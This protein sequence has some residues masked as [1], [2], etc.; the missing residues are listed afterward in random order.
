VV[1]ASSITLSDSILEVEIDPQTGAL[2][3]V[4]HRQAGLQLIAQPE[5]AARNPFAVVLMDGTLVKE[6]RRCSIQPDRS[7]SRATITWILDDG[8]ELTVDLELHDGSGELRCMPSLRNDQGIP[9]AAVAYPYIAGIGHLSESVWDDNLVHP[10]ATGFLVRNPLESLPAVESET[11]GQQP[12]VLGLYPE[13]FSGSTMQFMAYGSANRGGFY[14]ATE[15]SEGREKWLNFYR[16]GAGDL[17]LS[18][19]HAPDNYAG[20]YAVAPRYSTV[21]AALDGGTWYDAAERYKT[22]AVTQPWVAQGKTSERADRTT[23]LLQDVGLCT[24]GIS[25]RHDRAAWLEEIHRIAG[26]P[27]LHVLGPHW[28]KTEAN[29]MG[30]LPGGLADWFPAQF[31]PANMEMIRRNGDYFVPFEF[32]LFFGRGED[33]AEREAGDAAL[34][35]IP[36]P[37]FSRDAYDFPFLCPVEPFT[38]ELHAARDRTLVERYGVDGVYYDISVNN[39]RHICTSADH[40]HRPGDAAALTAAYRALMATTSTAM[41][42]ASGGTVIPQ[43]TEMINE[44]MIPYISFYQARAEASPASPFEAWPFRELIKTGAAEKIPLFTY[45]YHEYGPLRLD[46]W[47]KLSREQGELVYFILGRIFLQGGLIELN[48]EFS[49]LETHGENYDVPHEHYY[50]F[51]DRRYPIDGDVATF[52][53]TL[54]RMR[55]GAANRYLAYGSMRRPA[56]ID[57]GED[58]VEFDY[59]LYNSITTVQEYEERGTMRVPAVLQTAW[60]ADDGSRAWLLLNVTR[61]AREVEIEV[62]PPSPG[63]RLLLHGGADQPEELGAMEGTR[64][65]RVRLESRS[66]VM[67]EALPVA[68]AR[69]AS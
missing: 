38:Q 61:T 63:F 9:V 4:L 22:W 60:E 66:P 50:L 41:R 57:N 32:D 51:D 11:A 10:F 15:D 3:S 58:T 29:Y 56:P 12:T 39:V 46:G 67:L 44:Q 20:G 37:P 54:S 43:G 5:V 48:Y 25:S 68:V 13:G 8:F 36:Q 28:P 19:W 17:R 18:V 55:V 64:R 59:F 23:W 52:V 65:Q 62:V 47:A 49:A 1:P 14:I 16:H 33:R 42:E 7:A 30:E 21:L 53:G 26:T 45:V 40:A 24:F 34:Q 6:W 35:H 2:R 69:S 31:S 27:I